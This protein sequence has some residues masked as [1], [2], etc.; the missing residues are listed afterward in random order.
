MAASTIRARRPQRRDEMMVAPEPYRFSRLES[1]S[2]TQE[3][4]TGGKGL[5][6]KGR[7]NGNCRKGAPAYRNVMPGETKELCNV[8]G[9]GMIRHLWMTVQNRTP[10]KLRNYIFRVYWDDAAH[11]SVE[12]PLGDFFGVAHG[13]STGYMTPYIGTP[14]GKG[15]QCYFPMPFDRR[16]RMT[17]ENDTPDVM[18]WLFY[19]VDYTLGDEIASEM[20]R[21]HAHFR[22]ENR[23]PVGKDYTILETHG[24]P[25]VYV[26]T[27]MGVNPWGPGWWG[28]GE[29]KFYIDGDRQY[30][31]INGTGF[32]DY[33]CSG[34]GLGSHAALY[35]GV[36]YMAREPQTT[37]ER[38]VSVYRF[39]V[40]DPVYFQSDLKVTVQQLG[41]THGLGEDWRK[42]F[43]AL[44]KTYGWSDLHHHPGMSDNIYE[45]SDDYCSM[46][47]WY[48][49]V[50]NQAL[51][52]LP[53]REQRTAA[54]AREQWEPEVPA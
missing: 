41:S 30:P 16:C 39:H 43:D 14:E 5:G 18:P 6:G 17:L 36:N 38:F 4:P 29:L 23:C 37:Q 51:P 32:E 21:F 19:Q 27:M 3:N 34:W 1:R 13:R 26:G 31:T 22:R 8:Q 28:E 33:I 7:G 15:F 54:I 25:G 40:L 47:Y 35:T 46:A 42:D 10:E 20:G 9:P 11:P 50:T 24:S 48:Q 12:A 45:R 53:A 52:A 44:R 2:V 49:K